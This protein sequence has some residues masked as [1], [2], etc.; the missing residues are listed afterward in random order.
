MNFKEYYHKDRNIVCKFNIQCDYM[1]KCE[2]ELFIQYAMIYCNECYL[3]ELVLVYQ[4]I[5]S[6]VTYKDISILTVLLFLF[7]RTYYTAIEEHL[8]VYGKFIKY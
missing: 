3:V 1:I 2:N 4:L 8:K 5:P 7:C 6:M